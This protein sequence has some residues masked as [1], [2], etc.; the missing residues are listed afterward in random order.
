MQHPYTWKILAL[1]VLDDSEQ[2][3]H[4]QSHRERARRL[5]QHTGADVELGCETKGIM[6][7]LVHSQMRV[8]M[9]DGVHDALRLADL[10]KEL[11]GCSK[12]VVQVV[13]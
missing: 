10:A 8:G 11:V 12:D 5:A 3:P 13:V 7:M 2:L 4:Q 1:H 6:Q 9:D